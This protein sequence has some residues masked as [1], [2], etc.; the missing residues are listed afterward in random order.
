MRALCRRAFPRSL[1]S[2][3]ALGGMR[4]NASK[5]RAPAVA[6]GHM[7]EGVLVC[8]CAPRD[9]GCGR[10]DTGR[11]LGRPGPRANMARLGDLYGL[12]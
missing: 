1:T 10:G 11:G 2:D 8:D 4:R 3:A 7:I 12:Q 5:N 9:P 6:A